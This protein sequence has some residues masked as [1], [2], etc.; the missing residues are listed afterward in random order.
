MGD[1]HRKEIRMN[2]RGRG[3]I[4]KEE[5]LRKKRKKERSNEGR[6]GK[7]YAKRQSIKP[8]LNWVK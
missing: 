1:R 8:L 6:K 3:E 2:T 7:E 5:K 4:K